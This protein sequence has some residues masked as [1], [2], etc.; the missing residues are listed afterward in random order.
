MEKNNLKFK[1]KKITTP[2]NI[3]VFLVLVIILLFGLVG[4]FYDFSDPPL[5]FHPTRQLHSM[6]IARGMYY[7]SLPDAIDEQSQIAFNQWKGEGQIEPPI[8]ERLTALGY[9]IAGSPDL[10]VARLLS[11]IFWLLGGLGLFL[12]L[13]DLAGL[14][15]SVLGLAYYLILPYGVIAS[16]SFQP[17]PL[18]IAA[19]IW[20]WWGM[21]KWKKYQNWK[22]AVIGGLLSGFAIFVKLPAFFF[23]VPA[24]VGL[25]LFYQP[26]RKT[27]REPKV[28]LMGLLIALPALIYHVLGLYVMDFLKGQTSLRI[29]PELWMDIFHYLNWK[30]MIQKTLGIEF[31]LTAIIG[32]LLINQKQDRMMMFFVWIGYFIYGMVFSYHIITH[33]YYQVP[34][35][36]ILAIGLGVAGKF[37]I[38]ASKGKKWMFLSIMFGVIFFW[39]AYNFWET[40]MVL[41]HA[42]FK[43]EIQLYENL[44]EKV[45]NYSV[46]S[47]TPDYGY[48]LA[49][50]GWKPSTNWMSTAD[51]AYRELGGQII[52]QQNL[53]LKEVD[54]KDLFLITNFDEFDRQSELKNILNNGFTVFEKGEGYLIFDLRNPIVENGE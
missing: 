47:I 2:Q 33:D 16:R 8:M 10:R 4:R 44:G 28:W 54:D 43:N 15:S 37:L 52:D 34:M 46:V 40:R 51:L 41:K 1:S 9:Q 19:I 7:E 5:D 12:L 38:D 48:R 21:L 30:S 20:A 36:P 31:F 29:F 22:W 25:V 42:N 45:R 14:T 49:Y 27:I 26:F 13:K 3:F 23:V 18:M 50:W 53:L 39:S 6:L 24:W 32:T 17:E 11:I 35:I